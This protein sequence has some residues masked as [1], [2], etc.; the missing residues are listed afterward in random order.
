MSLVWISKFVR[1]GRP[2][3]SQRNENFTVNQNYSA[4]LGDGF[5]AKTL[6]KSQFHCQN[7]RSGRPVLT[8]GERRKFEE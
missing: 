2:D 5:S 3:P 4:R 6:A 7:D 1:T 8:N